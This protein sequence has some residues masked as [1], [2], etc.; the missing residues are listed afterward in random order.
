MEILK[1]C[2]P[3]FSTKNGVLTVANRTTFNDG[4]GKTRNIT[5]LREA[6]DI[7]NVQDAR[8][9]GVKSFED[10]ANSWYWILI[11]KEEAGWI[12][13]VW[14]QKWNGGV[15][16]Y[17]ELIACFTLVLESLECG[18]IQPWVCICIAR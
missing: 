2:F 18:E 1:R 16:S 9:I 5:D 15:S 8:S 13:C 17:Q 11:F 7:N 3:G 6:A 12:L 14:K 4:R 10:Y